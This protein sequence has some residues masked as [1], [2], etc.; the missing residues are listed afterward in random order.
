MTF[1]EA[2][3][4]TLLKWNEASTVEER[5]A[6]GFESL[7]LLLPCCD[8]RTPS[9]DESKNC[10]CGHHQ[11]LEGLSKKLLSDGLD[12]KVIVR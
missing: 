1:S 3:Y 7:N 12:S 9:R 2:G 6:V 4:Q 8:W 11:A 10:A 5:Y